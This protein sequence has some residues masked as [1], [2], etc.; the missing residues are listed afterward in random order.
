MNSLGF[1]IWIPFMVVFFVVI[2]VGLVAYPMII[3]EIKMQKA[4][5]TCVLEQKLKICESYQMDFGSVIVTSG[6]LFGGRS[7]NKD[8]CIKGYSKR[9]IENSEIDWD[10]CLP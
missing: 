2:S 6:G 4:D 5:K 9:I 10:K 3:G 8:A 7:Y 1:S